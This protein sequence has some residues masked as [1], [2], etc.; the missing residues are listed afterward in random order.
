MFVSSNIRGQRGVL[1]IAG[2]LMFIVF[3]VAFLY[4]ISLHIELR[5]IHRA[6]DDVHQEIRAGKGC[7]VRDDS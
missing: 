5:A 6:I 2:I 1:H 4:L 3:V 7:A